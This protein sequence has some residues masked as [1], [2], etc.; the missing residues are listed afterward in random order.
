M[1]ALLLKADTAR[2]FPAATGVDAFTRGV[3]PRDGGVPQCL[4][5]LRLSS[6]FAAVVSEDMSVSARSTLP[7][8]IESIEATNC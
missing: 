3:A 7:A 5:V 1:S 4:L 2:Y 8:R 6:G